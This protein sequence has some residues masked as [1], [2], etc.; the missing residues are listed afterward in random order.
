MGSLQLGA[1]GR[2]SECRLNADKTN[3][4][5]MFILLP[6]GAKSQ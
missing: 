5:F 4:L 3:P 2:G 6:C 1:L